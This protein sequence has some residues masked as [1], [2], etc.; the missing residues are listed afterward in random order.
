LLAWGET[1]FGK[2]GVGNV[3]KFVQEQVR[4]VRD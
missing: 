1:R 4:G 2:L 3:A